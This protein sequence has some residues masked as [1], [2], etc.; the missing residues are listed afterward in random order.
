MTTFVLHGGRVSLP[1]PG[2]TQF[3][4][5]FTDLVPKDEVKIL[6]CYWARE[7]SE[8]QEKFERDMQGIHKQTTKQVICTLVETPKNL[9]EKLPTYDVLYVAGGDAP[10]L[11]RS[12]RE[13]TG[14][15]EQ[16]QDKVFLGSS[17]GA[18]MASSNYVLSLEDQDEDTVHQGLSLLP[19]NTLCHWDVEEKKERKLKLLQETK[20]Y[21]PILALDEGEIAVF[22]Y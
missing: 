6:L 3:Y 16:L 10:P 18:F 1:T 5:H 21:L 9:F 17:M 2:S 11:E 7:Q 22:H 8:W 13:L 20:P 19:I 15:K 14:L 12:Y 4:Q